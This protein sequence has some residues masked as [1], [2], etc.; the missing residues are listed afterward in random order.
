[1]IRTQVYLTERE[2]SALQQLARSTGKTQS[3]LIRIAVDRL[4]DQLLKS[5]RVGLLQQTKGLWKER[6]DLPDWQALRHEW[7]RG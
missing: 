4:A 1:M 5:D 7:S 6:D 3:E 2:R